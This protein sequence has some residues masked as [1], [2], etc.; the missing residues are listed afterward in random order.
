MRIFNVV[1][2]STAAAIATPVFAQATT[3]EV[4][5]ADE[6]IVFG[7]GETR[8]VQE[9]KTA[10]LTILTPGTSPLKEI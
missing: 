2:L 6:I 7:R 5:V 1:L 4:S 9:L 10:D 8:Q 3:P